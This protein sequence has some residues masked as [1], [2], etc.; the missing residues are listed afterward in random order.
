MPPP[1]PPHYFSLDRAPSSFDEGQIFLSTIISLLCELRFSPAL[2]FRRHDKD[3]KAS[4]SYLLSLQLSPALIFVMTSVL[5]V[6]TF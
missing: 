3:F 2:V 1:P 5:L 4:L 6:L